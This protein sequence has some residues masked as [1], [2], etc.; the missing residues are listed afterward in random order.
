M[1]LRVLAYMHTNAYVSAYAYVLCRWYTYVHGHVCAFVNV[2]VSARMHV[3]MCVHAY[4][5]M[6]MHVCIA[7]CIMQYAFLFATAVCMCIHMHMYMLI[8]AYTQQCIRVR[9]SF[10]NAFPTRRCLTL[11]LSENCSELMFKC[12][13]RSCHTH[14]R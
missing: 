13:G 6:C 11:T 5:Y 9:D 10:P 2:H 3:Y 12:S 14:M 7:T 1:C 4:L 8:Q